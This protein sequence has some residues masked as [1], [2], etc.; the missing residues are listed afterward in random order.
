[1]I[2]KSCDKEIRDESRFCNYCGKKVEREPMCPNCNTK[3]PE[4]SLFCNMCGIQVNS[5]PEA[6]TKIDHSYITELG[7]EL[8]ELPEMPDFDAID[9]EM[10]EFDELEVDGFEVDEFEEDAVLIEPDFSIYYD[11]NMEWMEEP[12]KTVLNAFT[13]KKREDLRSIIIPDGISGIEDRAFGEWASLEK[14]VLPKS[15]KKIG[16]YAFGACASLKEINIPEN[17]REIGPGAFSGCKSLKKIT[18]PKNV[19]NVSS[20]AFSGCESLVIHCYSGSAAENAALEGWNRFKLIDGELS[21]CE[22][23]LKPVPV[24]TNGRL[25]GT[26]C[27]NGIHGKDNNQEYGGWYYDAYFD[28]SGC[29]HLVRFDEDN[30]NVFEHL[31]SDDSKRIVKSDFTMQINRVGIFLFINSFIIGFGHE[32]QVIKWVDI[33]EVF[34]ALSSKI[35]KEEKS[36]KEKYKE[37][38]APSL[39]SSVWVYGH[40]IYF[41]NVFDSDKGRI[42]K[43]NITTEETRSF[44]INKPRNQEDSYI[45]TMIG[46]DRYLL[47]NKNR[48][49]DTLLEKVYKSDYYYID[50]ETRKCYLLPDDKATFTPEGF[51]TVQIS[52]K[53]YRNVSFYSNPLFTGDAFYGFKYRHIESYKDEEDHY[54][55]LYKLTDKGWEYLYAGSRG[56]IEE[57]SIQGNYLYF[58]SAYGIRAKMDGRGMEHRWIGHEGA[59]GVMMESEKIFRR[60][61]LQVT[62][63]DE[64]DL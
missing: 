23:S 30:I 16:N 58:D 49:L 19:Q 18:I 14:V 28:N 20:S 53:L 12:D 41:T 36:W 37:S 44:K 40:C 1:M 8:L 52:E 38:S 59:Y 64:F 62:E 27:Y 24:N 6:Q 39:F 3:L 48:L 32:G 11:Q 4:G 50:F 9:E 34:P 55:N 2:C 51:T 35:K 22:H 47:I 29:C 54:Y 56:G 17:V 7:F 21:S 31:W 43:Y 33:K 60:Y 42:Y 63:E 46:D 45:D 61:F 26:A 25:C 57:L 5:E 10:P 13:V 15:I